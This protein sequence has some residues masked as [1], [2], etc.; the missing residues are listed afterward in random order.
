[1]GRPV[2]SPMSPLTAGKVA[3]FEAL[4]HR[5]LPKDADDFHSIPFRAARPDSHR[6]SGAERSGGG[7]GLLGKSKNSICRRGPMRRTF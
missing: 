2:A 4:P 7:T 6:E 3:R 1:M 5:H